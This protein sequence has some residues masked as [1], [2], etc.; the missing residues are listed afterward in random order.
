MKRLLSALLIIALLSTGAARAAA[1]VLSSVRDAAGLLDSDTVSSVEY[2]NELLGREAIYVFTGG[3]PQALPADAV[4]VVLTEEGGEILP[5][6]ASGVSTERAEE[7]C[8][9]TLDKADEP[10]T[11]AVLAAD[12]I[13]RELT[14]EGA[15]RPLWSVLMWVLLAALILLAASAALGSG[16]GVPHLFRF[17]G[18]RAYDGRKAAVG[19]L[20]FRKEDGG[21]FKG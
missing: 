7:I 3:A 5:G 6:A 1:P 16:G 14:G 19:R 4:A 17:G 12:M 15:R 18:K 21:W 20:G 2:Y 13:Y 8:R 11:A 9:Q 10:R